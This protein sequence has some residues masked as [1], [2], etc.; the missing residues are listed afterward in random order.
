M[1]QRDQCDCW[2]HGLCVGV[3]SEDITTM[4]LFICTSFMGEW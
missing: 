2:Y 3:S 4:D 1:V